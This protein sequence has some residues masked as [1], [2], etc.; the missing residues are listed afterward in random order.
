MNQFYKIFLAINATSWVVVIFGIKKELTIASLPTW[1]S[2]IILLLVPMLLSGIS[3]L[4]TLP[5]SKDNFENCSELEE[6]NHSFLPTYLGYFF[7][8][9]GIEKYKHLIFVYTI[10]FLF[11]YIAQTQYYN[12]IFLL[13]GYRFYNAKTSNGTKIFIITRKSLR[14]AREVSFK[15]LRRINDTTYIS[16]REKE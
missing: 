2:G 16:W 10:I 11:T 6:V 15:N 1:I 13:F 7:V 9:L 14:R 3:V 8:G 5:L 12:P 4:L